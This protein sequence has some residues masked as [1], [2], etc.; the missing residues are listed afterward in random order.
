MPD[1]S[2]HYLIDQ[3]AACAR[4]DALAFERLY[5]ASS[6]HLYA[7][8]LRIV[9]DES[10]A[11]DCLQQLYVRLWHVAGQYDPSRARPMTW[12]ATLARNI[13]I[14]WLRR[15]KPQDS[16]DGDALLDGLS[17]DDDPE[18]HS[19]QAQLQHELRD[20]LDTLT[21]TQRQAMEL[22]YFQG[23][24]H[25]ELAESLAQPLGSIK[26]WIRRGLEKLKTCLSHGT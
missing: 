5:R 25:S 9:R 12:L 10:A 7:I 1:A 18:A 8:L 13:G 17:G 15:Q 22:A 6:S 16:T 23:L 3:L 20:C 11:Q 24:T 4:G 21:G 19:I 14:D 26:S 2:Q